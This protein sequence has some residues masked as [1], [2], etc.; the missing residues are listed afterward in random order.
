MKV[1]KLFK[2]NNNF[3]IFLAGVLLVILAVFM[4]NNRP[5]TYQPSVNESE[6]EVSQTEEEKEVV[7][8][9]EG[10]ETKDWNTFYHEELGFSIKYPDDVI[11]YQ[12]IDGMVVFTKDRY[13]N[14]ATYPYAS[15]QILERKAEDGEPLTTLQG[16]T[17][18]GNSPG[19]IE[20]KINNALGYKKSYKESDN[21]YYLT[22]ENK[23]G[24]VVRVFV[25]SDIPETDVSDFI[26]M[27]STFRF[28]R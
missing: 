25:G 19:I 27:L 13:W 24:P 28:E 18:N 12:N 14:R 2:D 3:M 9:E 23:I 8:I 20:A 10:E 22:D 11:I 1:S 17:L 26:L 16:E 21:N 5:V 7:V 6:Q 4:Q 15:I